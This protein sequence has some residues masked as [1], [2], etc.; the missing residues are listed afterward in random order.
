VGRDIDEMRAAFQNDK[1]KKLQQK[2]SEKNARLRHK[3]F[4]LLSV[5][6][7]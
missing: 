3:G 6:S 7:F 4:P 2:D 5:F 1:L